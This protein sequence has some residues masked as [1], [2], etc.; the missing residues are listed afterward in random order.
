MRILQVVHGFPPKQRAGTEMYTYYLSKE[1]AKKHE[2]HVFYPTRDK[3]KK[4]ITIHSFEREKLHLHELVIPNDFI[5]K[6]KRFWDLLL[7]KNTYINKSVEGIFRTLLRRIKP[8][9]IHFEHLIGLSTTLIN[10]AKEEFNIPIV[11]TLHDYWFM[12]PNI[13]LI[14][15]E[16][17][18][19]KE[20]DPSKCR[21]CWVKNRAKDI[22]KA[23]GVYYIPKS[24]TERPLEIVLKIFNHP[25]KFEKR[26]KYLKSLLLKADKIISPSKFLR[27]TFIRYGISE[28]KIIYSENGYNLEVFKGFKKKKNSTNKIIFGFAGN[29]IPIKG[30][31][32]LVDAFLKVP[33]EKAELRIYGY[34]NPKSEYVKKILTKAK[35]KKNIKFMGRFEDIKEPYSGI[36]VLIFPSI[37]YENCPLVLAEARAT[38]TPVIASN[39]GAIPEFVKHGKTGLLFEPNNPEDLYE[40]IMQIIQ[41]PKLIEKFKANIKLPRS[42]EEQAKEIEEI[43][44]SLMRC[45]HENR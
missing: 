42:I 21:E 37:W 43:Y 28:D 15:Y 17:I 6:I 4:S 12:C 45:Y 24:L 27:E 40:K 44:K 16:H 29:V 13:Q 41:N 36:D 26:N 30:V 18:I 33:E 1:L 35:R 8:D 23:L 19:C 9:I 34:Y 10:I 3:G 39:L 2:V 38:K 20:P 14:T 25:E 32:V 22:S 31:H 5:W 11:L 7:I